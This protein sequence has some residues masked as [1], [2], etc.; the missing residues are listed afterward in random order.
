[1]HVDTDWK[2]LGSGFKSHG[3]LEN[4]SFPFKKLL[5]FLFFLVIQQ[6]CCMLNSKVDG[7]ENTMA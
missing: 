2:F 3:V 5:F 7:S 6:F 1:M 4:S